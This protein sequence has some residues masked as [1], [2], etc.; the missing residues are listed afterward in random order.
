MLLAAGWK[1]YKIWPHHSGPE[2]A[3]VNDSQAEPAADTE[4]RMQQTEADYGKNSAY[5]SAM[6]G[7]ASEYINNTIYSR[8]DPNQ[9]GMAS[10]D[11]VVTTEET[12]KEAKKGNSGQDL[13][14]EAQS[15]AADSGQS[16]DTFDTNLLLTTPAEREAEQILNAY[17]D[18]KSV[19]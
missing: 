3:E 7:R 13:T 14:L 15:Q 8:M 5:F 4:S 9:V 6:I 11:L 17:T 18:R 2:A 1:A 19:V 16:G 10:A 12:E